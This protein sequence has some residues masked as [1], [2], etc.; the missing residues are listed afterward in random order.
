MR[1]IVVV[2][3]TAAAL[4]LI[5]ASMML[6]WCFWNALGPDPMTGVT[7]GVISLGIDTFKASLPL[8]ISQAVAARRWVASGLGIV[9]LLA[10]LGFSFLSAAGSAMALRG[11]TMA[12]RQA[13]SDR[14]ARSK[15]DLANIDAQLATLGSPRPSKVLEAEQ[16]KAQRD[17]RWEASNGCRE[18][19]GNARAFCLSVFDLGVELSRAMEY[20][21]LQAKRDA[22]V[23]ELQKLEHT[24]ARRDVDPQA[25]FLSNLS[26][27]GIEQIS[28][29]LSLLVAVLVELGGAFGLFFAR[30]AGELVGKAGDNTVATTAVPTRPKSLSAPTRFVRAPDGRLMIE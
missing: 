20:E 7:F 1:W 10:C 19:T 6:N 9:L 4:A 3:C 2:F 27:L 26:G 23:K 13:Q 21:R 12:D 28:T 5:G 22:L 30:L 29:D 11:A 15:H 8:I 24:G 17:R 14:L 25:K 18:A 16:I